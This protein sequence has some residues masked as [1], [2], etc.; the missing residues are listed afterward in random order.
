MAHQLRQNGDR[1]AF[2][3][4]Y[5]DH[6][7]VFAR[8]D[9]NPWRPEAIS[10]AFR[11]LFVASGAAEG[12]PK[13]PSL[14]TL[15]STSI[16][17]LHAAGVSLEVIQHVAGHVVGTAVTRDHYLVVSA[18]RTRPEFEAIAA[19]LAGEDRP[20]RSDRLSDH[21]PETEGVRPGGGEV[22]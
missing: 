1:E 6:G 15:R 2:G 8:P 5:A 12:M 16:T 21:C 4:D 17:A 10:Q 14:K 11:R 19:R 3:A 20:R 9:G 13:V 7:L 22:P 18:E